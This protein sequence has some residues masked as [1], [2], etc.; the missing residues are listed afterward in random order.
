MAVE[1]HLYGQFLK[2]QI[3]GVSP[4]VWT[5]DTIK[6]LLTTVS[7]VPNQDTDEFRTAV[8]NEVTG[9]GYTAG[10]VTVG[11]KSVSYDAA[12]NQ[13]RLIGEDLS[14]TGATFTARR[15][16]FYKSTGTEATDILIGW[17]DFGANQ[18][19]AGSTFLLDFDQTLGMWKATAE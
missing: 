3:S 2:R 5:T 7:Y 12:T 17:V 18:S 4:V 13:A 10:G 9:T 14:W 8:S 15:C 6:A 19:P 11:T 16:V 1:A